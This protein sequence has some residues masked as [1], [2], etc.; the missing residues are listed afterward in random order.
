MITSIVEAKMEVV[1]L[2]KVQ[3]NCGVAIIS[4]DPIVSEKE[5]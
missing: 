2:V 4:T 5:G 3:Q 1:E